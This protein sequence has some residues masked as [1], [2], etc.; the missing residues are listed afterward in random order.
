MWFL[1]EMLL[2]FPLLKTM[3]FVERAEDQS[4]GGDSH[5]S[6]GLFFP[7]KQEQKPSLGFKHWS[8]VPD[9]IKTPFR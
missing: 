3:S 4:P 5:S 8:V 7:W 9:D 6:L 2:M 1:E